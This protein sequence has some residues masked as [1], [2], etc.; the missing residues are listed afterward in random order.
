MTQ[1]SLHA[2][3]K[4]YHELYAKL[5]QGN[6]QYHSIAKVF[7]GSRGIMALLHRMSLSE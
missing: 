6:T 5:Y 4:V 2:V 7:R 3:T 1:R